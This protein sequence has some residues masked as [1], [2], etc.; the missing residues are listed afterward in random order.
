MSNKTKVCVPLAEKTPAEAL[1][2]AQNYIEKGADI[3]ELRMDYIKNPDKEMIR[4]L[5]ADI[6]FPIIATNRL[7]DEG[8][9]FAGSEQE[10]IDLLLAAASETE[11]VDIELQTKSELLSQVVESSNC[12]IIS[13]HD[14]H[15]T[16]S[17]EELSQVVRQAKEV[18]DI[19]KFAVMPQKIEDTLTVLSV[20]A[21]NPQTI[22][23]SMGD[24]GKYTRVTSSLFGA[25]I[26]FASGA[27]ATAPG[28]LDIET[29]KYIM[30]QL[31]ANK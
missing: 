24:L 21:N 20:L 17:L 7:Q 10:R 27:A 31:A 3:L 16:P 19:A 12:S 14:F 1:L 4:K 2:S 30:G 6:D 28:Q 25:P 13:F 26:T 23:I 8:G 9:F 11:Y 22:G 29:T 5:I 18:G 15:K